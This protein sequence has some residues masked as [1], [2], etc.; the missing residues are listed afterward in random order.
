LSGS[1]FCLSFLLAGGK[2]LLSRNSSITGFA[3]TY[4]VQNLLKAFVPI[5]IFKL[6]VVIS[7]AA[8]FEKN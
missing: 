3:N 1:L 2:Y 6:F 5:A 4:T 8:A 7:K